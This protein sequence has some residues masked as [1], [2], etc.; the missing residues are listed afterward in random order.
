MATLRLRPL[1]SLDWAKAFALYAAAGDLPDARHE[2]CQSIRK[3]IVFEPLLIAGHGRA[4]SAIKT[5]YDEAIIIKIVAEG[6]YSIVF[7]KHGVGVVF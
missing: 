7:N 3:S 5:A 1:R 4:C 2:T 6:V